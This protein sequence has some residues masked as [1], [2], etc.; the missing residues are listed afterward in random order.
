[1]SPQTTRAASSLARA[2]G[3]TGLL[4][5]AWTAAPAVCGMLL[6]AGLAPLSEWLLYH[7]PVGLA[8]YTV[9]FVLGAGLGFLPTYAQS[10]LG[11]WVFGVAA[12]LPAAL[13]GFTGGGWLGYA[14]ARRVS[15]D[16]VETLIERN[17]K[18]RAIRDAL[19]GR[20][21]TRTFLVVVL[22]R[23]PPNSP[24]ALTNLVMATTG[25]P[26]PAFLAGTLLGM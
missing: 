26:L 20:S 10:I 18:A 7:R 3:P 23:L 8:V 4:G 19:V 1:M 11:G 2:L 16:R 24:F 12:G 13:L 22:L 14:V 21:V 25:V 17:E 5:L 6:L 15:R 9:V